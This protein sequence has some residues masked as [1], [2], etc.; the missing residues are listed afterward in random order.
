MSSTIIKQK[1]LDVGFDLCGITTA[2]TLCEDLSHL[3]KY[4]CEHH[5]GTMSWLAR[6]PERR[7]DPKSLMPDAKS[8]ICCALTYGD[9]GLIENLSPLPLRERVRVRVRGVSASYAR[10]A[11]YHEVIKEKLKK[12][13]DEIKKEHP[14]AKAKL[15]VD[16]SLIL[17]K[18]LA[19]RAGLGWIG[20][21]TLLINEKFG[22]WLLLGEII[23]DIKLEPDRPIQNQCGDCTKCIDA[24]PTKALIA[25]HD[26]NASRCISY[27]TIEHKGEI[28]PNLKSFIQ[29]G[30]YG[31]DVCLEVCPWGSV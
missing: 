10:G 16:T 13:W 27:L 19:Q 21:N 20:K 31:C 6:S 18:A 7:I 9:N 2:D 30:M 5:N 3:K 17:E 1:A 23:T 15:C 26:L 25:E 28:D 29:P 8:V 4:L 24:C 14:N 22:P 12:L 11:D